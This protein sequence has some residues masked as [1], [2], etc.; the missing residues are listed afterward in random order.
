MLSSG[1]TGLPKA[2]VW[3]SNDLYAF[4]V[5]NWARAVKLTP[6]DIVVGFAPANA[7]STGYVYPVLA[8]LLLGATSVLLELWAARPALELI[9]AEKATIGSAVPTQLAMML[10]E[11]VE[12]YDLSKPSNFRTSAALLVGI[13]QDMVNDPTVALRHALHDQTIVETQTLFVTTHH[14]GG[15][16]NIPFV[17]Q[18]ANAA[19]MNAT[20]WIE[21][22][23]GAS[24]PF[25]QLQYV[26]TVLL[27]FLGLNWP[28]VSVATLVK[29]F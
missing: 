3:S 9:A 19:F 18:N 14:G 16:S 7:G 12:E 1:S 24:G 5:A 29:T 21:K 2:S 23:Q 20:F 26:Q 28:H 27:D 6:D 17:T 13:S 15:V 11:P 22:V 8:P 4:L 25:L 10:N